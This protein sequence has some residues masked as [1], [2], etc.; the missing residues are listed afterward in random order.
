[1]SVVQIAAA[2]TVWEPWRRDR[3]A[4]RREIQLAQWRCRQCG[5]FTIGVSSYDEG[6]TAKLVAIGNVKPTQS[7]ME[8]GNRER[9]RLYNLSSRWRRARLQFLR[10]HPLCGSANSAASSGLPR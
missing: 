5:F 7:D 4:I 8:A 2:T 3:G 6:S 9:F 10:H 1:M